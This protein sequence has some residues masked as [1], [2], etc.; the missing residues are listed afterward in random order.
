MCDMSYDHDRVEMLPFVPATARRIADIGCAV[1]GFGSALKQQRPHL[2]LLWGLEPDAH[3]A[4]KAQANYD[5]VVVGDFPEATE[6]V[7]SG[8]FDCV[9]MNDVLEHMREPENALASTRRLLAPGGVI[10]ASIPN[11]R[12]TS[13][14]LP[15]L[16]RGE[17]RYE[18]VGILDR[19]HVRFFTRKSMIALF[20][21]T[22][23]SVEH[24]EG[25]N[26]WYPKLTMARRLAAGRLDEFMCMQFA[27][28][29]RVR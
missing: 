10:V 15:L 26:P 2:E 7:P 13:A 1:G 21:H 19:T 20:E 24:V 16:V 25:I 11:V 23:Y 14:L 4:S 5:H 8:S 6:D 17:W 9:V 3:A 18:D 28:V 29:A 12:H 22:G 27:L